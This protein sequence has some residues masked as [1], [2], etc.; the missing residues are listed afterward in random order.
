MPFLNRE[1]IVSQAKDFFSNP[2]D[3]LIPRLKG[4][5]EPL[6]SIY[7]TNLLNRL[8]SFLTRETDNKIRTF[9]NE[10][11]VRYYN[12]P[13]SELNTRSFTNI[14]TPGE[15]EIANDIK[16]KEN[17]LRERRDNTQRTLGKMTS[18]S[19]TSA[20]TSSNSAVKTGLISETNQLMV[21]ISEI[22]AKYSP[23]KENLLSIL[24]DIQN[25]NPGQFISEE[26]MV[27]VAEYLNITKSSVYG[28][29]TFYTMFSM[30]P[31]GKYIIRVCESPVC[32]MTGSEAVLSV[33]ESKLRIGRGMTT[34]DGLFTVETSECLGHCEEAP[35]MIINDK[36]Y[37]NIDS[38]GIEDIIDNLRKG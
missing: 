31:R 36:L 11:T 17:N 19:A 24:H 34:A 12:V 23:E 32:E 29:V 5:I 27:S 2:A 4:D 22:L 26:D 28:V 3:A 8:D 25:N 18:D 38:A 7:R 1:L 16:A 14:N 35:C 15:A 13:E 10:L 21:E 9:L 6:H 33:I 30:K 20:G 37:R